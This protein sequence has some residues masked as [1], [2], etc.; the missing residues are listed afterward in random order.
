MKA[1]ASLLSSCLSPTDQKVSEQHEGKI[2]FAFRLVTYIVTV[3]TDM[4]AKLKK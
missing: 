3:M 4:K 1:F 2:G